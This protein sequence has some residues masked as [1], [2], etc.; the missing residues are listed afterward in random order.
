MSDEDE[1]C[2]GARAASMDAVELEPGKW[3]SAA[4][5][6]EVSARSNAKAGRGGMRSITQRRRGK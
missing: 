4:V 6:R 3:Y 5:L 2:A 1:P